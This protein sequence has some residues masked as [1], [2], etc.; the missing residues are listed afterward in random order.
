MKRYFLAFHSFPRSELLCMI[1]VQISFLLWMLLFGHKFVYWVIFSLCIN[2]IWLFSAKNSNLV[3][4]FVF[5][6]ADL[7]VVWALNSVGAFWIFALHLSGWSKCE[8]KESILPPK[9]CR[10]KSMYWVHKVHYL[11]VVWKFWSR[12]WWEKWWQQVSIVIAFSYWVLYNLKEM[13]MITCKIDCS[14]SIC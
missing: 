8:N 12:A 10:R 11:P 2:P 7:I 3:L 1:G 9:N 13:D 5:I 14:F 6:F 4:N